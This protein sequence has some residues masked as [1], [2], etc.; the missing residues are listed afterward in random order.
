MCAY[1]IGTIYECDLFAFVVLL[2]AMTPSNV[3]VKLSVSSIGCDVIRNTA[4]TYVEWGQQKRV[5]C[6]PTLSLSTLSSSSSALSFGYLSSLM[7]FVF[8]TS[9]QFTSPIDCK[10]QRFTLAH[11]RSLIYIISFHFFRMQFSNSFLIF[12]FH[13]LRFRD[14]AKRKIAFHFLLTKDNWNSMRTQVE[15]R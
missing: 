3:N 13:F 5:K 6:I 4:T 8:R 14:K 11:S 1:R 10:V 7:P 15:T 9:I 12:S 2:L